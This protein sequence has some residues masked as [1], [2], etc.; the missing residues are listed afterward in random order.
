MVLGCDS[1]NGLTAFLVAVVALSSAAASGDASSQAGAEQRV[2][3]ELASSWL[4][5]PGQE[6]ACTEGLDALAVDKDGRRTP[7][8]F[9]PARDPSLDCFYVYPTVSRDP[10]PLSDL[11]AGPEERE[12]V[13]AQAGRL[14]SRCRL[15]API[16][17]QVTIFGLRQEFASG[18]ELD[19]DIPYQDVLGAWRWYMAHENH[20]RGVVLIGHSQGTILLQR[21]IAEEID[22]K[23][24]M[25][26]LVSAFLAGDPGLGVPK[27]APVG[28]DFKAIPLC[29]S[30]AETGCVYVWASYR[31]DDTASNRLF[32]RNPG[33]GL[34]AACVNPAAP[35]GGAGQLKAYLRKPPSAP[36]ADPPWVAVKGQ[37]SG[38]C[39]ADA[40][41]DALRINVDPGRYAELLGDAL[42]E[43]VIASGWG[44]HRLDVNLVQGNIV[45]LLAAQAESWSAGGRPPP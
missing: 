23:P 12:A 19:W 5:R 24:A 40:Q 34:V 29:A 17:R 33:D 28:G 32:G 26:R 15:F 13:N 8:P 11:L 41:G 45:D 7:Q 14:T 21:L 6:A 10:T 25:G 1:V 2:D 30:A 20:G 36:S 37:L 42:D 27:G 9:R 16:Y 18:K 44:L 35:D 22:G 31:A 4:C 43:A 39:V 38:R 3:Y